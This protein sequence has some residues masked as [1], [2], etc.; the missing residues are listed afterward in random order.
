VKPPKHLILRRA[1]IGASIAKLK[2][3]HGA[4][5]MWGV[6]TFFFS[7]W[8]EQEIERASFPVEG[9]PSAIRRHALL[10]FIR[11]NPARLSIR[12]GISQP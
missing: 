10:A 11:S 4:T 2:P 12:A 9:K 7:K 6:H 8:Q 5:K 1:Q 3:Q